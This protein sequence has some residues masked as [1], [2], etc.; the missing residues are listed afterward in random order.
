MLL[1]YKDEDGDLVQISTDT[2]LAYALQ[3]YATNTNPRVLR[4]QFALRQWRNKKCSPE[5][6]QSSRDLC[7]PNDADVNH[8]KVSTT[9]ALPMKKLQEGDV[10]QLSNFEG[11]H[12]V[13]SSEHSQEER[14]EE[15]VDDDDDQE[16]KRSKKKCKKTTPQFIVGASSDNS[17]ASHWI[18]EKVLPKKKKKNDSKDEGVNIDSQKD[19][20]MIFLKNK[21][22]NAVEN[23]HLRVNQ[24]GEKV[25]HKSIGGTGPWARFRV[26][27]FGSSG[28]IRLRSVG[29]SNLKNADAAA[30]AFLG[31]VQEAS[32]SD[33]S[34]VV[35]AN[36]NKNDKRALFHVRFI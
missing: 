15:K 3:F 18:V 33:A 32:K 14:E 28:C 1:Q 19:D 4:L 5:D 10:I 13:L 23:S 6:N 16:E 12:L 26:D 20:E 30:N 11:L 7:T 25:V 36:L 34:H 8:K 9:R 24:T 17:E 27:Y 22:K 31:I 29:R 35:R 21:M 2:E